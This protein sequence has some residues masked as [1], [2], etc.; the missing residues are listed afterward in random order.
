MESIIKHLWLIPAAPLLAAG[1]AALL[2]RRQRRLSAGLAIG[3]IS[4]SFVVSCAAFLAT[5]HTAR[6]TSNF[7]WFDYGATSVQLGWVLD[8]LGAIMAVMVT[9]VSL[10]IFIYSLGYMAKDEN[11]TRFFCFLALFA[12]AMLGLIIA[13]SLLLFFICWELVGLASYLLI[14]FWYHK[15]SAAAAA[16]KAFITTRIGDVVFFLG[17]LLL[18]SHAHTLLFYDKGNG[19]L[20]SSALSK[21]VGLTTTGGIMV[22]TGIGLLIFCGAAGKSGQVPLHVWLPDAMEGPTP[23]SALIHAATMVA[24]GVFLVARMY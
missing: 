11:F 8:P 7:R 22:T 4:L 20:E 18:Y 9:G 23:V 14:G 19:C 3:A 6:A 16:K 24:A 1:V 17:M 12:A 5:L 15:P 10:L 13:N 2:P 21:M